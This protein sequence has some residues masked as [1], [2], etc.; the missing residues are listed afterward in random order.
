MKESPWNRKIAVS[1]IRSLYRIPALTLAIVG[2]ISAFAVAQRVN[3][4]GKDA[5]SWYLEGRKMKAEEIAG[6][7]KQ[8]A[9]NPDDLAARVKILGYYLQ[10]GI[11]DAGARE[12]MQPHILWIIRNRPAHE[13]ASGPFC[14]TDAIID[15]A[16]H[17][18][19][20]AAW[21]EQLAAH[22]NDLA[23]LA[24]AALF[25]TLPDWDKAKE[26]LLA[27]KK[28]DPGNPK[29]SKRIG[30]LYFLRS[31]DPFIGKAN[32]RQAFE[33]FREAAATQRGEERFDTL[34]YLAAAALQTGEMS[35]ARS[36]A[37]ELLKLAPDY[38]KNWNYGNAIYTG[39][40]ILGQ[41]ALAEGDVEA[42]R[43]Y[44]LAAGDT[45]GSPQLNSFGPDLALAQ[46]LL[47]RGENETVLTFL[48]KIS[49]F[50]SMDRGKLDVWMKAIRAGK[51]PR[52]D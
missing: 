15:A 37:E 17:K 36:V 23:V 40:A 30:S 41:V 50:W 18:E 39:N 44:L 20:A 31:N 6:L 43:R 24:N 47:D 21:E 35:A 22:P 1:A 49:K 2:A 7:Q 9:A 13:A 3:A 5:T 26:L 48:E 25:F 33:A 34:D 46:A 11:F 51:K 8:V 52:L 28:L 12:V 42:A 10:K 29:W 38:R 4:S 45:P 27:A 32:A 19:Q 14:M 16:R